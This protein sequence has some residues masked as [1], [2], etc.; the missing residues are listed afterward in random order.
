VTPADF[1]RLL[2]LAPIEPAP[3]GNGLAM[4]AELFRAA[5]NSDFAVQTV[6][7]PVAGQLP[8]G[9]SGAPGAVIA[10]ADPVRARAAATTLIGDPVWRERLIRAGVLPSLARAA[11]PGLADAVVEALTGPRPVGV[12]VMRS[13][14]AP[15]GKAVAERLD[16]R[17]ITLDLDEDDAEFSTPGESAAYE[18]LLSVFAPL[19]DGLSAAS[20]EEAR[21][22][23]ERHEVTVE[24]IPN[25]VAIVPR[26]PRPHERAN[27]SLLFV[28]NLTY[29]PNVE[30]ARVLV[31]DVLP[32]LTRHAR[33]AL[34]GPRDERIAR[35]AGPDVEITG[36]VPDLAP[37]Y[38]SA[39]VVVAPLQRGAGTRI[40]LL[41][42]FAHGVPVV[43]SRAAAAGLEVSDG[44][45]V[46]LADGPEETAMA[47]DALL[48]DH[49]P[50]EK[51]A[52]QAGRL[53]RDRYSTHV[54][55][56]TIRDFFARASRSA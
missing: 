27:G 53:L 29:A 21:A 10:P 19:F 36:F 49:S 9:A 42:A 32:R 47:V 46:L 40:K 20:A 56:P 4:R 18:R 16:A 15:L 31:Q 28:G 41:E 45:H 24:H 44:V 26:A 1:E 30:A 23:G 33:L 2:L 12:H 25:A 34:V 22:I 5:A 54:V 52:R 43:A 13:Y 38:A 17:W 3:T 48:A 51:L 14:L 50:G 7:V 35:L 55:I 39:D 6:V 37:A 8:E 11:S